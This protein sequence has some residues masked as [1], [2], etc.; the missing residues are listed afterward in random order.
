MGG[1]MGGW[2]DQQILVQGA[3]EG[4]SL[5]KWLA[6]IAATIVAGVAVEVFRRWRNRQ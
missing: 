5:G 2:P 6:G 4:W 1:P 3:T